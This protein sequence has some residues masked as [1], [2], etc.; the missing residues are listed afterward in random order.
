MEALR[1]ARWWKPEPDGRILCTLCPRFCRIGDGQAGFCFIRQVRGGELVTLG[2]GRT[3]GFAID[4]VEKKPLNHYRPGTSTLSFGTAGCNLGCRFCQNWDISKAK[5]DDERSA[6]AMP[7][8]VVDLAI[9]RRCPS[10]SFTYNDPVI[11]A[12][13][14]ID[15]AREGKARGVESILVT[16]GYVTEEARGDLYADARAT[17]VDLKA[18]T[19]D[20]YQKATFSHLEPVLSTLSW[21]K[22]ETDVWLEITN[23]MIPGLNDSEEE[24]RDLSRWVVAE[25]GVDV[26]VHF[27]AFHPDFKMR[28]RPRTPP[29]T[30]ARA[31]RIAMKEGVR[32]AYTGN[33]HD[34]EGGTTFCPRCREAVVVRDWFDIVAY[35]LDGSSCAKCGMP[36]AGV[37][38]DEPVAP[39]RAGR[40]ILGLR[41]HR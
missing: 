34:R 8:E 22:K 36:I 27:T 24:T 16:A 40:R 18:F 5:I 7:K 25:L 29:E 31:R 4:P 9:G 10:M 13:Y 33:V 14:A 28:D 32:Y 17:N 3:T 2:Y 1:Q 11:W 35:R 26:P 19:E 12:E 6:I 21:L 39:R 41:P 20:F 37:W 23:L 38:P 30:L 15:L